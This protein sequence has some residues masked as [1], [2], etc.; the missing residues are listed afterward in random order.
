MVKRIDKEFRGAQRRLNRR[1]K[2]VTMSKAD[3]ASP[4]E[5]DVRRPYVKNYFEAR[6]F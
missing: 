1:A 4:V 2:R 3:E 5:G 6:A